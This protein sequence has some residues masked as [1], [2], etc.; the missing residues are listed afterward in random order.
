MNKTPTGSTMKTIEQLIADKGEHTFKFALPFKLT[1]KQMRIPD[2]YVT[3]YEDRQTV[4]AN[5]DLVIEN[6]DTEN[7]IDLTP[8]MITKAQFLWNVQM[9]YERENQEPQDPD[10]CKIHHNWVRKCERILA[11]CQEAWEEYDELMAIGRGW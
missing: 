2:L 9:E 6:Y 10:Y 11:K 4:T 1:E 3:V 8:E 7:V 5:M